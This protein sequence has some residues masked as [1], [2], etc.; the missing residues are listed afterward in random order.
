MIERGSCSILTPFN[1]WQTF[2]PKKSFILL[3]KEFSA[4]NLGHR[5]AIGQLIHPS[6]IYEIWSPS[7]IE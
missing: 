5:L 3:D 1:L 6:I 4:K 7:D 2:E